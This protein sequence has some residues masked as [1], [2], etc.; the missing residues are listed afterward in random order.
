MGWGGVGEDAGGLKVDKNSYFGWF[1][2]K[3]SIILGKND[4]VEKNP[5]EGILQ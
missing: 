1:A 5:G 3:G 4:D 2:V